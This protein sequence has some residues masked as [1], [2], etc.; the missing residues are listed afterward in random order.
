MDAPWSFGPTS[1]AAFILFIGV[2][3][4]VHELGHFLAAKLFDIKVLKFSLGFGP[5]LL[6]FQ[7]GETTYQVAAVPLGGFVRMHGDNP[8]EELEG[9]D[10]E[11][12]FNSAPVYQR[13]I[14]AL[15]GP[16]FN[17]TFPIICFFAYFL[18][19][20]TVQAPMVGKVDPGRPAAQVDLAP[21]DRILRI[22]GHRA[23][24]FERMSELISDRAGQSVALEIQ[25]GSRTFVSHIVPDSTR[26]KNLFG[27]ERQRGIIGVHAEFF[28]TRVGVA[29]SARAPDAFRTGDAI[30]RV[31]ER[32]VE[33]GPE[34][35][36]AFRQVRGQ[37]VRVTVARSGN[38]QVG[39]LVHAELP[40]PRTF[41]ISVP[42]DF[43]TLDDLGLGPAPQFIRAVIPGGPADQAGIQAGDRVVGVG[44]Q[45]T[46]NYRSFLERVRERE[47]EPVQVELARDGQAFRTT[48][49]PVEVRCI[50]D[51]R[52]K[53]AT[54]MDAGFG[55][56]PVFS[57]EP[58]CSEIQARQIALASW[59]SNVPV[60][61]EVV[62]LTVSE[63]F[64]A[65]VRE[66]GNVIGSVFT[67]LVKLF[68]NEVSL[69]NVGGPLRV[70]QIAAQAA[71]LGVFAYL[72][73]LAAVSVNLGLI[74]LLPIPV[75]DGGHLLFCLIEAVKRRP[76]SVRAREYASMFGLVFIV[77][78]IVLALRNDILALGI[79]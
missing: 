11:R 1:V 2:L 4:F 13:A 12:A 67:G 59:S 9:P 20:P 5:P 55:D 53:P 42:A 57:R 30:L 21:G 63:A 48:L 15:A 17:L 23:Y 41:M 68:A 25:R 60:P 26:T 18:L 51:V 79:F 62:N 66:T 70:F 33:T 72:G 76:L 47:G 69:D 10:K 65:S 49:D 58:L 31:G 74:N 28:G 29:S 35:E 56:G 46:L 37:R 61:R 22:D 38:V 43:E 27:D 45:L 75:F 7:R 32:A 71:E 44:G 77:A 40:E 39:S 6:Q 3:I 14:V 73:T 50:H 54:E 16:F 8:S 19:G 64:M 24:S 34:L 52:L 78:L 36:A